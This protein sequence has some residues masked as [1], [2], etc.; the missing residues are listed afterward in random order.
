MENITYKNCKK[1][2]ERKMANGTINAEWVNNMKEKM[3]IFLLNNRVTESEYTE[4][5]KMLE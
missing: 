1:L 4:L 5:L 2:V 3:D